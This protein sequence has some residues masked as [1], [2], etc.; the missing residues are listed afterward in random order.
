MTK[1]YT[2]DADDT[3]AVA[4]APEQGLGAA[5]DA[6]GAS[7]ES[8][9]LTA[10]DQAYM[11]RLVEDFLVPRGY[12]AKGLTVDGDRSVILSGAY[13]RMLVESPKA[14][15]YMIESICAG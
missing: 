7:G 6:P 3:S 1:T 14:L 13:G 11:L 4:G 15:V 8:P 2:A 5:P 9:R 12:R 10:K